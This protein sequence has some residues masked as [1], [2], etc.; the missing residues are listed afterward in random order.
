MQ[1]NIKDKTNSTT[2]NKTNRKTN[3][4]AGLHDF[5]I[6]LY[7]SDVEVFFG[8]QNFKIDK[9]I[10][11]LKDKNIDKS[12]AKSQSKSQSKSK[13]SKRKQFSVLKLNQTHS[14]Q[15]VYQGVDSNNLLASDAHFTDIKQNILCVSTADCVPIFLFNRSKKIVCAIHAGWKGVANEIVIKSIHA[16]NEWSLSGKHLPKRSLPEKILPEKYELGDSRVNFADNSKD[17]FTDGLKN[18]WQAWIGPHIQKK[19]FEIKK[20][21]YNFIVKSNIQLLKNFHESFYVNK[22]GDSY[23]LDLAFIVKEQLKSLNIT[24]IKH[25]L[26]DT[27]SNPKFNS[28]RKNKTKQRNISYIYLK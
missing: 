9:L 19:S 15:V 4:K 18:D 12:Q 11:K 14:D 3:S 6:K 2:N 8:N 28:Y 10:D 25:L 17:N 13:S 23:Y 20:D 24:N 5:G 7:D 22:I 27:Y 16:M 1:K 26:I 21:V